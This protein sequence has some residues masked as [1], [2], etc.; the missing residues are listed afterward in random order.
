MIIMPTR[1]NRVGG[2]ARKIEISTD[3]PIN[4]LDLK[5]PAI[6]CQSYL[7]III[8]ELTLAPDMF[9]MSTAEDLDNTFFSF[10]LFPFSMNQ[11]AVWYIFHRPT[12][13]ETAILYKCVLL[14]LQAYKHLQSK[15][16]SPTVCPNPILIDHGQLLRE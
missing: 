9:R 13:E 4:I 16:M 5:K 12:F 14:G 11:R 10:F 6:R 1:I 3:S 8:L 7:M 15:H 2:R